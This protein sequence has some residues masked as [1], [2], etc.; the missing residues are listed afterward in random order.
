MVKEISDSSSLYNSVDN[1]SDKDFLVLSSIIET[2]LVIKMP[3]AKKTMIQ[4]RLLKRL[5][6]LGLATY[7]DYCQ[8]MSTQAGLEQE[9]PNFLDL[10]TTNKTQFFREDAHFN[11]VVNTILPALVQGANR[12][13][14]V[15]SAG[16]SSGE[17]VYTLCM[18]L[19]DF[20]SRPTSKGSDFSI[21]GTDVSSRVLETALKAIYREDDMGPIPEAFRRK[22]L[23]RSKDRSQRQ[24][25]IAPELR[26]HVKFRKLNFLD[27]HYNVPGPFD[28]I[29][30]RNV[31]IYFE[32]QQQE[33]IVN[34]I[35]RHL[36]PNGYLFVSH[37]ETLQALNVPLTLAGKSIY[38]HN[39]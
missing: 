24:I 19:N 14:R 37:S 38:L 33:Q 39:K 16:C 8:L 1:I 23:L 12:Q 3:L 25:R 31:L 26:T 32:R 6:A 11:F 9:L 20:C 10:S 4:A 13:I 27:D 21:L 18:I 17:E 15:W 2:R 36:A 22:Y 29:F 35:C 34:R 28:F 5:R 30:F 7:H